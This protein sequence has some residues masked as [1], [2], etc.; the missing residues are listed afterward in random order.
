MSEKKRE[1]FF[2]V[3][4]ATATGEPEDQDM[5]KTAHKTVNPKC[6]EC[7]GTRFEVRILKDEGLA[8]VKCVRCNR[9]YL[10]LDSDDYWF[11]VI[12]Q[13]FPR[14]SRCS[15]KSTSFSLKCDYFL[16]D[17]GDVETIA[18]L[19]TCASCGT[20]RRQM[21]VDIDYTDTQ[22]LIDQPLV[23][24][25]NP[26]ILYDL[27]EVTLYATHNDIA[28]VATYLQSQCTF[29]CRLI[30]SGE[31]VVRQLGI[32]DVKKA[33]L[34]RN[35]ECPYFWIYAS[36]T[37]LNVPSA[38]VET[39]KKESSFWKRNEVVRISSPTTMVWESATALL[40]HLG[41]SNEYVEGQSIVQKSALF[42][43]T[44][45]RLLDWLAREFVAWRGHHCFDNPNVHTKVFG[46]RFRS[47]VQKR[48]K[49]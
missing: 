25:S 46:E 39:A 28:R 33:I 31:R 43:K 49:G 9:D 4:A 47:N 5:T 34:C 2:L 19:T 11:D 24:C 6:P 14:I 44:T 41:F 3:N 35:E 32:D 36:P 38:E 30:E 40:Y 7:R 42:R 29:Y 16:R 48:G 23:F 12:Q 37:A 15:C 13:G 8:S 26:R 1:L 17:D 22:S 18:V 27:Q 21:T 45:V 20:T 10:L